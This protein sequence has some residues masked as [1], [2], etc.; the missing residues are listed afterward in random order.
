MKFTYSSYR[1][2]RYSF[3]LNTYLQIQIS[4]K[5]FAK[6]LILLAIIVALLAT[7]SEAFWGGYGFGGWGGWGYPYGFGFGYP[8]YGYGLGYWGR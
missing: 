7:V 4:N 6:L 1:F 3:V 8:Y 5:M 2:V